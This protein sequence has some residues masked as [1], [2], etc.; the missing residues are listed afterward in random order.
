MRDEVVFRAKKPYWIAAAVTFALALGVF[1]A[2]LVYTLGREA[3]LLDAER[4]ELERRKRLDGQIQEIRKRT[5]SIRNQARP[6][7]GLLNG[8]PASRR[9]L[10]LVAN[11]L[12]PDDWITIVCDEKT[13]F[14]TQVESVVPVKENAKKP[15]PGFYVP[16]FTPKTAKLTKG[17]FGEDDSK[18][19]PPAA[20]FT[21]F[22]IEG[23]TADLSLDS[24]QQML[25]RIRA[26]DFV[27]KVDLLSDD[28]VKPATESP[29]FIE[30][31]V[32][33]EMRRFVI[34]LEVSKP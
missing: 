9:V 24:V 2:G 15:R 5:E 1:T 19:A 34:R 17:P 23:Y 3:K 4:K 33:P 27:K 25:S 10:S 30:G 21:T 8:W 16:G 20:D 18:K 26:V 13:Y 6:L 7:R 32:V 29:D 14:G 22:I 31:K 28:K 11:S 12:S